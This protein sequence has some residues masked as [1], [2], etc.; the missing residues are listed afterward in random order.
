VHYEFIP[1][2]QS[3]TG[4][5][6]MKVLQ[7]LCHAVCRKQCDKWQGQWFL[8]YVMHHS[9]HRLLCSNSSLVKSFL[10]ITQPLYSLDLALSDFWL[11][12]TLKMDLMGTGFITMGKSKLNAM[13]KLQKIPKEAFC[14]C[15]QQWQD[16]CSKSERERERECVCVCVCARARACFGGWAHA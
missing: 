13:A 9:T 11:F 10:F 3:I 14:Q 5:F 7:R 1:P 6:Y 8:H 15:F 16:R 12:P 2:G 4:H